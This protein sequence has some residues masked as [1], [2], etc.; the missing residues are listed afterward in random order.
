MLN[1]APLRQTTVP[2]LPQFP[3]ATGMSGDQG[4]WDALSPPTF[5]TLYVLARGQGMA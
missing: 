2:D 5:Y 3:R 4:V 1:E